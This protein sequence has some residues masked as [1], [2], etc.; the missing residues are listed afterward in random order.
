MPAEEVVRMADMTHR[1][2]ASEPTVGASWVTPGVQSFL[3]ELAAQGGP[4]IYEL[5][6]ADAR[7]ALRA[8]QA[9]EVAKP[10]ADIQDRTVPGGPNGQV[11]VRIV[12]PQGA[13]GTL[14]AVMYFHGGGWILGD[15]DTHD[16]LVRELAVGAQ[17]AVVFV[18]YTPSP[19]AH[20]PTA[21][22]QAYAATRWVAEQGASARL[23]AARLML[24]GDS[25]GG[26]MV[27]AVTLLAKRRGGPELALQVMAYPVTGADFDTPS[28]QQFAGGPWLTRAAMQWFWDAY[29]PDV[30]VRSQP[31]ASP[32][33]A[34]LEELGGLPPA[35]LLTGENDVL[36]DEG[37]A[38]AH[39]LMQAGVTVTANRYLGTIHDFLLLNPIA[40]TAPTRGALAQITDTL[41]AVLG[42]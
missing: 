22:E 29:A 30:S 25:A 5:S 2:A 26:T 11:S 40:D 13:T 9:V 18:N 4:P 3:D 42:R 23:D 34:G 16:R 7:E 15:A 31:T 12:R 21:I 28:Y 32:L 41:R 39:R 14:P 37:E 33:R 27:A 6:P 24:V 20:Y 38:Y 17:A 36:R 35:L 10:A 19:E 1:Q 8:G